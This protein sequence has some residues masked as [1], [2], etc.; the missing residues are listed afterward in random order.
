MNRLYQPVSI[1]FER[2]GDAAPAPATVSG[3]VDENESLFAHLEPAPLRRTAQGNRR[4]R[5][6]RAEFGP[7]RRFRYSSV[8]GFPSVVPVSMLLA[9]ASCRPLTKPAFLLTSS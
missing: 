7:A 3:A 8:M 1:R 9:D 5:G 6:H 2:I 4:R